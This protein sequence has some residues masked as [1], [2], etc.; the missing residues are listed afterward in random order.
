M[1]LYEKRGEEP[2]ST[3]A[4]LWRVVG[5]LA[6]TIFLLAA[7]LGI[8]MAGY[9]YFEGLAWRDAFENSAML[10]GGMGPIDKPTTDGGKLFA[11]GYALYCGL[12]FLIVLAIV[13]A[14]VV[15]RILHHFHWDETD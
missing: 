4:F 12:M 7:S 14:P 15:H 9:E 6:V 13:I 8:G 11:G 3:R 5:H 10:L 2:I 1:N